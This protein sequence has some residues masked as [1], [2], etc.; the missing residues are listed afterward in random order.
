MFTADRKGSSRESQRRELPRFRPRLEA[1]EV[2]ALL[3]NLIANGNFEAGNTGFTSDY[4]YSPE[5]IGPDTAYDI[6]RNPANAHHLGVSYGDH[7]SGSGFMMA[8]NGPLPPNDDATVWSQNVTVAPN[9]NYS[10]SVWTSN[11]LHTSLPGRRLE[12]FI[13]GLPV[14]STVTPSTPGVWQPYNTSWNSGSS[15]AASIRIVAQSDVNGNTLSDFALDDISLFGPDNDL[16]ASSLA[17]NT[18]QAGVDFAYKVAGAEIPQDKSPKAA[19]Y[20]AR[21]ESF[22]TVI[23]GPVYEADIERPVG[24]YGPFYVPTSVILA[25]SPGG[26]RPQDATHLL[27]VVDPP[28]SNPPEADDGALPESDGENN[29]IALEVKPDIAMLS[30][31]FET[32]TSVT[33]EYSTLWNPGPFEVSVFR[34]ADDT[35]DPSDGAPIA[36]SM[37]F[38]NPGDP[39]GTIQIPAITQDPGK[40]FLLVVADPPDAIHPLGLVEESREDNNL[41]VRRVYGALTIEVFFQHL[42]GRIVSHD[43]PLTKANPSRLGEPNTQYYAVAR[44]TNNDM[45]TLNV[46]LNWKEQYLMP[47]PR[48]EEPPRT[49]PSHSL[50]LQPGQTQ[51]LVLNDEP[52]HHYW[53]WIPRQSPLETADQ[54]LGDMIENMLTSA[55]TLADPTRA[56]TLLHRILGGNLSTLYTQFSSIL[57]VWRDTGFAYP[58]GTVTYQVNGD[59]GPTEVTVQPLEIRVQELYVAKL[60]QHSAFNVFGGIGT[61]IALAFPLVPPIFLSGLAI[62]TALLAGSA[63]AYQQ[64]QDPPDADYRQP[65][66]LE[67]LRIAELDAVPDGIWKDLAQTSIDLYV[68]T[69]AEAT[70]RNRADGAALANDLEWRSIQLLVAADYAQQAVQHLVRLAD[71]YDLVAPFAS[72]AITASSM[73]VRSYLLQNGLPEIEVRYLT[74]LGWTPAQ[75]DA[76]RRNLLQVDPEEFARPELAA[77]S[78]RL[79]AL[80][81]AIAALNDRIQALGIQ[82][83]ELGRDVRELTPTERSS[84]DAAQA[85]IRNSLSK[86]IPSEKLNNQ[87]KGFLE[88]AGQLLTATRNVEALRDDYAFGF[89]AQLTFETLEATPRGLRNTVDRLSTSGEIDPVLA[90]F[91]RQEVDLLDASLLLADSE[92][93]RLG[94]DRIKEIVQSETGSRIDLTAAQNLLEHVNYL[95]KL[96][97]AVDPEPLDM[98]GPAI[99]FLQ[100]M[101]IHAQPTRIVVTFS[102]PIHRDRAETR[103]NYR[104]TTPGRDGRFGTRDDQSIG[105]RTVTYDPATNTVT[106]TPKQR[107]HWHRPYRLTVDGTSPTGVADLAGNLLDGDGDGRAGGDYTVVLR[108]PGPI[109]TEPPRRPGQRPPPVTRPGVHLEPAT[110]LGDLNGDGRIDRH[111]L[112]LFRRQTLAAWRNPSRFPGARR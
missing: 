27:L 102:E 41:I 106:L 46:Q 98:A 23:G 79:S 44:L 89:A 71:L 7:T 84:L 32:S 26:A 56:L 37:I 43:D 22:A 50:V 35:L 54:A 69:K 16:L 103:T 95:R 81:G 62:E 85:E 18:A 24:E 17:W 51:D 60:I 47:E 8:V 99:T 86:R 100:R 4:A 49:G 58:T 45:G 96:S 40:P 82:V 13:N 39:F 75:I 33:F 112:S 12:L 68:V 29:I 20:W 74:Q 88:Q 83:R 1:L 34:S 42:D 30:A 78:L 25:N 31:R 53:Q 93:A 73:D 108:G 55:F 67:P 21:G 77:N 10:F 104:L 19:L 90:E 101:G 3:A 63:V 111:D 105:L 87:I 97:I 70:A 80:A 9:T 15:Q 6:L 76:V 107:L 14:G 65:V 11:T 5:N 59:Y 109:P 94:L 38:P 110:R 92:G 66:H 48:F 52:L 72:Q 64:A 91:L 57:T 61:T 28:L 2:R 36:T